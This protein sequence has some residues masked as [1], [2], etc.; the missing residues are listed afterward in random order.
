M[1]KFEAYQQ[2]WQQG[3]GFLHLPES[4]ESE[5]LQI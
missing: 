1:I 3:A 4:C 2:T 5:K